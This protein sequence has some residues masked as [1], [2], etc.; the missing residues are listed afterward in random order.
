MLTQNL[1]QSGSH[2]NVEKVAEIT[3]GSF[4]CMFWGTIIDGGKGSATYEVQ[5]GHYKML[6][7]NGGDKV[8][9]EEINE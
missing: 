4:D 9:G 1:D 5:N 7:R 2:F 6:I 8:H 3:E